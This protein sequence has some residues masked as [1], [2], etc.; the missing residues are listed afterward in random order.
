ARLHRYR[1]RRPGVQGAPEAGAH[2]GRPRAGRLRRVRVRRPGRLPALLLRG[3]GAD[4]DR[5]RLA[6]R[7]HRGLGQRRADRGE[8]GAR[9]AGR[10]RLEHRHRAA[11]PPAQRCE[12]RLH[13]GAPAQP[14]GGHRARARVPPHRLQRRRAARPPDRPGQRLRARPPPPGRWPADGHR[15]PL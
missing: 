5:A 14:R 2:R 7:R 8:Q 11:G 3:G 15:A 10:A 9:R 1:S 4:G 13:R 12:R 6:R